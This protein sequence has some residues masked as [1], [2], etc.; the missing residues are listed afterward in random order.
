MNSEP[1]WLQKKFALS[2]VAHLP[3][4][5]FHRST[6]FRGPIDMWIMH[7]LPCIIGYNLGISS[8]TSGMKTEDAEAARTLPR[9]FQRAGDG[10]TECMK[11]GVTCLARTET[12]GEC[13]L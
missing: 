11:G 12:N 7:L 9:A 2:A 5:T 1:N 4:T 13:K 3:G 10:L 6:Q 8:E